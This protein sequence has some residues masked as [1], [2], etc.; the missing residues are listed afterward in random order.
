MKTIAARVIENENMYGSAHVTWFEAPE[1]T[2]GAVPGHFVM[3]RTV[4]GATGAPDALPADPC[5]DALDFFA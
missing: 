1:I 2:Q 5:T 4:E 3:L